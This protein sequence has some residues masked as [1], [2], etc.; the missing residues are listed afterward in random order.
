MAFLESIAA[1]FTTETAKITALEPIKQIA[2]KL[3]TSAMEG[4]KADEHVL[5]QATHA[6]NF[7]VG[8][9]PND[10]FDRNA[11][12]AAEAEVRNSLLEKLGGDSSLEVDGILKDSSGK[13]EDRAL[14]F[15]NFRDAESRYCFES[16]TREAGLL[17]GKLPGD[18][19]IVYEN[20][21]AENTTVIKTDSAGRVVSS[22]T[23]QVIKADGIRDF[24]QQQRCCELKD[25][26]RTDD[27]GHLL[28]REFGGAPEQI[29]LQPMDSYTNRHGEWRR[30]ERDIGNALYEG[31]SV[32]DYK[33]QPYY[34]GSNFRPQGFDVSYK[35]D[36]EII[37]RYVDNT[38]RGNNL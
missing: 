14:E 30:M 6:E 31:K 22:E 19:E 7:R 29:N 33:V 10:I 28:A 23:N 24:Y 37:N 27:A 15:Q 18:A 32:T 17:N 36:G 21:I 34:E 38:P 2:E 9:L 1:L 35:I 8:E 13:F 12:E 26:L 4:L 3:G 11:G 25:G 5:R 20:K 16:G